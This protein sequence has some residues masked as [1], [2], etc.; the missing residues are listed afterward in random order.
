[1]SRERIEVTPASLRNCSQSEI[2]EVWIGGP[3]G[4]RGVSRRGWEY[5]PFIHIQVHVTQGAQGDME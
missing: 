4:V 3:R 1:M 5:L 2:V